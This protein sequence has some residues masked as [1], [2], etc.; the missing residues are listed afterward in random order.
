MQWQARYCP[1]CKARIEQGE[2]VRSLLLGHA[3]RCIR[4]VDELS[5]E[6]G[7]RVRP[8]M[9]GDEFYMYGPG[10][11]WV[12]I[13]RIPRSVVMGRSLSRTERPTARLSF[14]GNRIADLNQTWPST[15]VNDPGTGP[16]SDG[17]ERLSPDEAPSSLPVRLPP[18]VSDHELLRLIGRGAYGE[19]WLGRS[20]LGEYRAIKVV[21]RR[22]FEDDRPYEREFSG[23][24]KFE[25]ISR[26]HDSQ[27]DILHVGRNGQEGYFYYV[28]ELADDASETRSPN[29]EVRVPNPKVEE[30]RGSESQPEAGPGIRAPNF[31]CWSSDSY[32][33][34]TL[35]QDLR[36]RGSLPVSECVLRLRKVTTSGS[37]S[38]TL[39]RGSPQPGYDERE[40]R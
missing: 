3:E 29:S 30:P 16:K 32:V 40:R 39:D 22:S 18:R 31:G 37:R 4:A 6:M 35:K 27:L 26:S 23:I 7:R 12:G 11:D 36:T 25:S 34:R 1:K 24:Q 38:D 17:G 20:I 13:E 28:M 10:R 19:V 33:A 14:R 5:H 8:L 15:P 2:T 9:W 21:Y